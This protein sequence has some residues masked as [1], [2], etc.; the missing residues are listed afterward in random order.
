MP[1]KIIISKKNT[2]ETIQNVLKKERGEDNITTT[3]LVERAGGSISNL[4]VQTEEFKQWLQTHQSTNPFIGKHVSAAPEYFVEEKK[5][6][7]EVVNIN[8]VD[9]SVLN[10]PSSNDAYNPDADTSEMVDETREALKNDTHDKKFIDIAIIENVTK[11]MLTAPLDKIK[12]HA[13]EA[14]RV[15]HKKDDYATEIVMDDVIENSKVLFIEQ[16][17]SKPKLL[18]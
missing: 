2:Y 10:A 13:E 15:Y 14:M 9:P 12:E 17:V 6:N 11:L 8:Q 3:A 7:E 18:Q 16:Q 1:R 4:P 5:L